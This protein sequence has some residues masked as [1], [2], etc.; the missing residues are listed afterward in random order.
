MGFNLYGFYKEL[1]GLDVVL[2]SNNICKSV[3]FT[4]IILLTVGIF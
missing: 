4:I 1:E 3:K 2:I